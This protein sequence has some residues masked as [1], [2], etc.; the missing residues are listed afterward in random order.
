[1]AIATAPFQRFFHKEGDKVAGV[2]PLY[3]F[4]FLAALK[5]Y[6]VDDL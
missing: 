6:I 2:R 3:F 1:M 4:I 5:C